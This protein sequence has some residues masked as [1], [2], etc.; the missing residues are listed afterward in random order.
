MKNKLI[1]VFFFLVIGVFN[2]NIVEANESFNF[3]ITEVEIIEN[4][5]KFIGKKRGKITTD[6][7]IILDA[8]SFEYNKISNVLNAYGDVVVHDTNDNSFIYTNKIKYIKNDEKIF[9]YEKSKA[10]KNKIVIDA[11]EFEYDKNLNII[12]ANGNVKIIDQINDTI[13]LSQ[14]VIYLKNKEEIYTEGSTESF[15][16]SKYNFKSKNVIFK[17][18]EMELSSN[19]NST[20]TD[21]DD[22]LYKLKKFT[23]FINDELLKGKKVQIT[24]KY[25]KSESDNFYFSDGFFNFKND[26]FNAKNTKVILHSNIF[27][28]ERKKFLRLENELLNQLFGDDFSKNDPRIIGVSSKGDKEKT[29]I[30]KAVYTSCKKNEGCPAWSIE[31]EKVTHDKIKKQLIYD[32]SILKILDIPV[33]YFPKFF[34]P[35]PT[36]KRQSGF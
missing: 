16:E 18:N 28:S 3:D 25:G 1:I 30:N 32:N 33:F 17:R 36:V 8:N 22:N 13:I 29:V 24:T 34:H 23:Y 5:N 31:S 10:I 19:H 21:D 26:S 20:I 12:K 27:Q 14:R 35:D 2:L 6:N 15:I 9:T 4:G 11:D 7:G